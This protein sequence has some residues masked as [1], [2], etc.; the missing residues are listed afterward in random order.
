MHYACYY[1]LSEVFPP[2]TYLNCNHTCSP[3]SKHS[4]PFFFVALLLFIICLCPEEGKLQEGGDFWL[5]GFSLLYPE[6]C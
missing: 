4:I 6:P 2:A 1:F 3:P 5:F